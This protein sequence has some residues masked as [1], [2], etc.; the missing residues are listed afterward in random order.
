MAASLEVLWLS[1]DHYFP[2]I[3]FSLYHPGL[4]VVSHPRFLSF[5]SSYIANIELNLE[6]AYYR[7][8]RVKLRTN[9]LSR[10]LHFSL[11][12]TDIVIYKCERI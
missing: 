8:L 3:I 1:V 9:S 10:T 11:N 7:F 6:S 4:D 5:L 12:I 2:V